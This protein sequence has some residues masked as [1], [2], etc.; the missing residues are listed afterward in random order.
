MQQWWTKIRGYKDK[1]KGRE[2]EVERNCIVERGSEERRWG[3][4]AYE[5]RDKNREAERHARRR[6]N[7][8]GFL[9]VGT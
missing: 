6:I 7:Q 8:I 2:S 4:R 9:R 3:G 5:R 1:R